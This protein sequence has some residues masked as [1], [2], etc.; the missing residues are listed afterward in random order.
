MGFTIYYRSTRKLNAARANAIRDAAEALVAGRTWLSCEPVGFHPSQ[1]DGRLCGGSKPNFQPDPEDAAAASREG[2][3]DGTVHD[4]IEI[5][6]KLSGDFEV[7]W[8]FSHD[9]DPGPIGYIRGGRCESRLREQLD[10][11][12]DL[13][14][15]LREMDADLDE[16]GSSAANDEDDDAGPSVLPFR[17]KGE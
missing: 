8:E 12:G 4:M 16:A 1:P 6:C 9:H 15:I 7:D 10:A 5:L 2:L 14:G 11:I 13:G 3:P 17:P